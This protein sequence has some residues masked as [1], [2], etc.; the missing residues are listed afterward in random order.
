MSAL[1][2]SQSIRGLTLRNRI[3][4]SP[5]CQY[6]CDNGAANDWHRTHW[7]HL[8]YSG[9]GLFITEAVAVEPDGRITSRD[10]GL[11][12]DATQAA[13][14]S[15]L[16]SVR[17]YSDMP[18]GMQIGHAGRKASCAVPWEGGAQVGE[19]TGGWQTVGPSELAFAEGDRAPRRLSVDE[20]AR[21]VQRF[22]DTATRA[23]SLGVD[24]FEI[25]AAHG[26]LLHQFLSPLSNQRDD[27]Y[28]GALENRMRFPLAVFDAV[29]AAVP[30]AIPVGVRVSASDWVDGGWDIEQTVTFAKQLKARGCDWIDAS[31]G[32]L[33]GAQRIP[34]G[35]GY[36]VP[37][38]E[39]LKRDVGM[40]TM[41]V[42][43]ITEPTQAETIVATGQADMVAIA[44]AMLY[45]PRWP[46]HAAATLGA[47]VIAPP[48]YWRSQPHG[49]KG[50]FDTAKP[51]Y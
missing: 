15:V 3:I 45:D 4:V 29:R 23:V 25:H 12:D 1:F 43:L 17:R 48:Q 35:P 21:L 18:I 44:R 27:A 9:A 40:P 37:F 8:S 30:E 51:S 46:W 38:A 36:Q 34:V 41:A 19:A 11:W 5:M 13:M 16:A 2:S 7:G 50:L 26:Y 24:A 39:R 32:G 33:S 47:Q 42:G 10:L 31:S 20:I 49:V 22:V 28:G 6:A 14:A